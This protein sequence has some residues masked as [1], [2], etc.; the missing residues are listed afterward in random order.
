MSRFHRTALLTMHGVDPHTARVQ[1]GCSGLD[2]QRQR[3]IHA[4]GLSSQS[5]A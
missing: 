4:H 1:Q 5:P 3:Q 2:A